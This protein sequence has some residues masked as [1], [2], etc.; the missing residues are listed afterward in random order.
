MPT[1]RIGDVEVGAIGL[2]ATPMSIEGRPDGARSPAT[3]R[4]ALDAA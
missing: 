3:V 4:A 2:G 1:R